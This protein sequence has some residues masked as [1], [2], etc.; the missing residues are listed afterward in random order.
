MRAPALLLG[1]LLLL[2]G[3][4]QAASD[5]LEGLNR[6]MHG[7]NAVAQAWVL[8]PAAEAWRAHVP[9]AAR[10]GMGN[11]VATLGEPMTALSGLAAGEFGLAG[12]ALARFGINATVGLAGWRDAAAGMGWK[13]RAMTPG[14]ALCAW[15]V[16]S[17][18]YLVL[19]L[20]GPTTLRDAGAGLAA[21]LALAQG[22]GAAPVAG[23]RGAEGFLEYER[24][25]DELRR[26]EAQSLD[27]YAVVR[28]A[29]RQRMAAGGCAA[30][31]GAA[32]AEEE[33]E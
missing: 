30:D 15:G 14:E 24:V 26:V 9:E 17:G 11:A 21:G 16:P 18:P 31:R 10:R 6:R 7:F 20:M 1:A 2:P 22:L 4:A 13:R 29:V 8:A 33:E 28:S 3:A 32:A 25:H 5:P 12:N 19:P 23:W 27:P